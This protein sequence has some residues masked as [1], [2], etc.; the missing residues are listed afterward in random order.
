M[1]QHMP[2]YST[3]GRITDMAEEQWGLLTRRQ[4]LG[5]GT[6]PR[7]LD[8]LTAEGGM[9]LKV[10]HGVYRL[11]GAPVPDH[12]DLRAAWLQLAPAIP[13]WERVERHGVVSHRSAADMYGVG[14]LAE[15]RHEFTLAAR[16]QTRRQDVG[17]HRRQLNDVDWIIL[18]GLPVTRPSRIVSDLLYDSED[19]DGVAQIISDSLRN[20]YDYPGTVA[21]ALAPHAGKFGLRRRDGVGLLEWM[22][23]LVGDPEATSWLSEARARVRD[24]SNTERP[25]AAIGNPLR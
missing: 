23:D 3:L 18:R 22:L 5:L 9:L 24:E 21:E 4:A 20:A 2:Q 14:H 16:Q 13:V 6:A 7:T 19:P 17:L 12:E 25:P 15:E 10:A 1:V 11:R 8:R